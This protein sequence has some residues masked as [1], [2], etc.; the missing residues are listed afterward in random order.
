MDKSSGSLIWEVK[1]GQSIGASPVIVGDRVYWAVEVS[2]PASDGYLAVVERCTGRVLFYSRPLNDHTHCTPTVLIG[3]NGIEARVYLGAN[4]GRFHCV[5]GNDGR[6]IWQ[7]A[8]FG[9][10]AQYILRQHQ[11]SHKTPI[12]TMMKIICE[13][14]KELCSIPA[15][16]LFSQVGYH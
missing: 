6:E 9:L 12:T 8:T 11:V 10:R 4:T 3:K 7:F 13:D 5:D 16:A 14:D 15:A 1:L 2:S